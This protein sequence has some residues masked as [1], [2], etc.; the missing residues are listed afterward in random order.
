M[1]AELHIYKPYERIVSSSH[2]GGG[3]VRASDGTYMYA[4][5]A[6]INSATW[7]MFR[8]RDMSAAEKY[9]DMCC[10][11]SPS[12]NMAP[13]L[14]PLMMKSPYVSN[15]MVAPKPTPAERAV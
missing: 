3:P 8:K 15:V 13:T 9:E 7:T 12:A 2:V 4:S 5:K 6:M 14:A 10:P 1:S 11:Q